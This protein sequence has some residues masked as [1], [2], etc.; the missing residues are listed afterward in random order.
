VSKDARPV[1]SFSKEP[2]THKAVMTQVSGRNNRNTHREN[3]TK[4]KKNSNKK[5]NKKDS[6][7]TNVS[8]IDVKIYHKPLI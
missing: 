2:K 8:V 3:K 1:N 5:R 4:E 6:N 7:E